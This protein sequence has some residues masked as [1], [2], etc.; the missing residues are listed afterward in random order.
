LYD[1]LTR[2]GND[3]GLPWTPVMRP[4]WINFQASPRRSIA[5]IRFLAEKPVEFSVKFS[6]PPG[7]HLAALYP[8]LGTGWWD[9]NNKQ[10]TW[11]IPTA[12]AI[13]DVGPAIELS[14]F[15]KDLRTRHGR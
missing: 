2:Y 7:A 12:S 8:R 14:P 6:A 3:N 1:L 15:A 5:C 4:G 9:D 13:P 10:W 11:P